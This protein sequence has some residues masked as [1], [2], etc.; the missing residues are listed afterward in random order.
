MRFIGDIEQAKKLLARIDSLCQKNY[1]FKKFWE[2]ARCLQINVTIAGEKELL[3][4]PH[5]PEKSLTSFGGYTLGSDIFLFL[6][7]YD[8]DDSFLARFLHEL[9]H[10]I[11]HLNPFSYLMVE[12]LNM[13][14]YSQIGG[15]FDI[16][17]PIPS[18]YDIESVSKQ[19][20]VHD[21][22]PEE[23]IANR[24]AELLVGKRYDWAWKTKRILEVDGSA[25]QG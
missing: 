18:G 12:A 22:V 8:V 4:D 21:R 6:T 3:E 2:Q 19:N 16:S 20:D 9:C 17:K 15:G 10:A 14:F 5:N 24:F 7:H 25:I 1:Y 13:S 23:D 11:L